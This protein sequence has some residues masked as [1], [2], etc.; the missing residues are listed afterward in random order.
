MKHLFNPEVSA[1]VLTLLFSAG[2]SSLPRG[3]TATS[4]PANPS[5]TTNAVQKPDMIYVSDF[6]IDPAELEKQTLLSQDRVPGRILGRLRG[7]GDP[8]AKAQE[9]VNILS[10]S[11]V[12]TLKKA[13]Y[14][15][16]R[17]QNVGGLRSDFLPAD[18]VLPK[19]GWMV[20]GWFTRVDEGN[21]AVRATVGFG[22]GSEHIEVQ[23]AVS[24][25]AGNVSEPFLFIGSQ[26]QQHHM[27]GGLVTRNPYAI[28][29]KMVLSRGA[30]ERDVRSEGAAIARNLISYLQ[31]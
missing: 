28:A 6:Y 29:A 27:P 17:F 15:A 18:A 14:P 5:S 2:C 7:D 9:L 8:A 10:D 16:Q 26:N 22:A 25:L 1:L 13:G 11:I 20:G 21:S 4:T 3:A 30:S 24:D 23:V 31:K 12:S 19:R